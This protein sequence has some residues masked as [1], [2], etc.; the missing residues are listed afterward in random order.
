[1]PTHFS[2]GKQ[3]QTTS[4][5]HR[6]VFT[7]SNEAWLNY[8][9]FSLLHQDRLASSEPLSTPAETSQTRHGNNGSWILMAPP[10]NGHPT[11]VTTFAARIPEIILQMYRNLTPASL[12][13][14]SFQGGAWSWEPGKTRH[15]SISLR[16]SA[17]SILLCKTPFP[18]D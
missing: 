15:C 2:E 1:M 4:A 3:G 14:L 7:S 10:V 5:R 9:S 13:T 8:T 16:Q 6:W 12:T 17:N 18:S 11:A